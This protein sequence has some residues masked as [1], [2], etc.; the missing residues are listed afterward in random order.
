MVDR[1]EP[2][3]TVVGTNSYSEVPLGTVFTRICKTRVDGTAPNL[4]TVELGAIA[5]VELSLQEVWVFNSS[6]QHVPNGYSAGLRLAGAG[7]E[8]LSTALRERGAREYVHLRTAP[9]V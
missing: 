1:I 7:V 8:A 2:D 3:G 9:Q 5:S 4:T 6:V